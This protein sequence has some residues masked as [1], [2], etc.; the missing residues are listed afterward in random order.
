[1][2]IVCVQKLVSYISIQKIAWKSEHI[3][4]VWEVANLVAV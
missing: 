4:S 3:C 2:H 1:M